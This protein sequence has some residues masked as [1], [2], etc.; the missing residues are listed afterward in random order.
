MLT[1]LAR[2][3]GIYTEPPEAALKFPCQVEVEFTFQPG[4]PFGEEGEL[5]RTVPYGAKACLVW[6]ACRGETSIITDSR[7]T[8]IELEL[9]AGANVISFTGASMT[10]TAN[11][12]S[13]NELQSIL[14]TLYYCLPAILSVDF[15][16]APIV[17]EVRGIA[18]EVTFCWGLL[19]SG[20]TQCDRVTTEIQEKRILKAFERLELI[21]KNQKQGSRRMLAATEYFHIACQL[22]RSGNRRWEFLSESLLNYAKALE[23]LFPAPPQRTIDT[24]RAAL[25]SLG[26]SEVEIEALFI[27]AIIL[28]NTIDVAHPN[29]TIFSAEEAATLHSYADAAEDGFRGLFRRLFDLLEKGNLTLEPVHSTSPSR[30]DR[31]VVE[32]LAE[33]LQEFQEAQTTLSSGQV[34]VGG[35]VA[36]LGGRGDTER[37]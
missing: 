23:V 29:L 9:K 31:R 17:S 26:Y 34:M 14:E 35:A 3:R 13:R 11:C 37:Q 25:K 33:S 7:L 27:P 20:W 12:N 2:P 36:R 10:I 22:N 24:A 30:E 18:G 21:D 32:R 6:N 28:R 5:G 15:L 1:Y 8:P 19:N 4:T 16:D